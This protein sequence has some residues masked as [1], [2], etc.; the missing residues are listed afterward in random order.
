M[1]NPRLASSANLAVAH[2]LFDDLRPIHVGADPCGVACDPHGDAVFV[3][4]AY[5]GAIVRVDGERQRRI[6]TLPG[7]VIGVERVSA[8]A[9]TTYGTVFAAGQGGALVRI[10]PEGQVEL[11]DGLVRG[12][13]RSGLAYDAK[14]H[15][16]YATQSLGNREGSVIS[17]D[18]VSGVPSTLIDGFLKPVG[19]A[20]VGAALVVADARTR[21]VYRI[22]LVAGRAVHRYQLAADLG[23]P[24][25]VCAFGRDSVLVTSYDDEH[26]RGHVRRLWL[27]GRSH[28]ITSGAWEPRGVAT[29]GE[30][31]FIAIRRAGRVMTVLVEPSNL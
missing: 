12:F 31:A 30:R 16:L 24:E 2:E 9:L 6:A 21:A 13:T 27:D 28:T 19:I 1:H 3:A 14:E 25:S 5:S 4:D 7:G 15:A 26:R 8:I 23:R 18:L 17:I 20:K 22:E 11:L 10:E 29:D